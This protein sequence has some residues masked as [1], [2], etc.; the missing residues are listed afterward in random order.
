MVLNL[1]SVSPFLQSCW[2][3]DLS[4]SVGTQ[5]ETWGHDALLE[6]QSAGP[7]EE[8]ISTSRELLG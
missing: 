4:P 7:R 3:G 8:K 6:Q 2:V 1:V 5:P